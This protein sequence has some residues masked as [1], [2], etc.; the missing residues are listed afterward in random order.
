MDTR[1]EYLIGVVA[2]AVAPTDQ[3][4]AC[5][6]HLAQDDSGAISSFI[7]N[8]SVNILSI[9]L[10]AGLGSSTP[11]F[12][13]SNKADYPAQC[14]YQMMITKLHA[15]QLSESDIASQ[16]SV[17]TVTNS[18]AQS[19]YHSLCTVYSPLLAGANGKG[20]ASGLMH[21][22]LQELMQEL[23]A[24]LSSAVRKDAVRASDGL[25]D[26]AALDNTSLASVFTPID[27]LD[28]WLDLSSVS[29]LHS[30]VA[31]QVSLASLA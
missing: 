24:G 12:T 9:S 30:K 15:G 7:E 21:P 11:R 3:R 18:S 16:V 25:Q 5:A 17:S 20:S 10:F 29:G 26:T 13:W 8:G 2:G 31:Q 28:L 27:E 14:Q 22:R 4:D 23:Q 6:Q 1:K 19:L